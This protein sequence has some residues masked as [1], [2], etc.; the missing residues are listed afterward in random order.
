[1]DDRACD[2]VFGYGSLAADCGPGGR[3]PA[4][5]R[6]RSA[7]MAHLRG[8]TRQWNVAMDNRVD[9]PGY[10]YYRGA[11]GGRPPVFVTFLNVVVRS[12]RGVN[13]V[14][15]PVSA[16]DL[17]VLDARERNYERTEVTRYVATAPRRRIWAYLGKREARERYER[18]I[19]T[20]RA[21]VSRDY[22]AQVMRD[23]G[24]LGR[25]AFAEFA[26]TTDVPACPIVDLKRVDLVGRPRSPATS[27]ESSGPSR[28]R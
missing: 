19:A 10:K 6:Q 15:V 1:M 21:V 17:E 9:V 24:R 23:F 18:G 26:A 12:G 16:A 20:G 22:F 13:G 14:L 4:G 5:A 28:F 25:R 11:W 27:C 2:Y 8:F 7:S 3:G